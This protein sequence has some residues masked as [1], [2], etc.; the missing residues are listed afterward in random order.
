MLADTVPKKR[1]LFPQFTR[2]VWISPRRRQIQ[3]HAPAKGCKPAKSKFQLMCTTQCEVW[4]VDSPLEG[5]LGNDMYSSSR[6]SK[7]GFWCG[8][9]VVLWDYFSW[10]STADDCVGLSV[11]LGNNWHKQLIKNSGTFATHQWECIV[12]LLSYHSS[13]SRKRQH[14]ASCIIIYCNIGEDEVGRLVR[15]NFLGAKAGGLWT[16]NG[17]EGKQGDLFFGGSFCSTANFYL[18]ERELV[19]STKETKMIH[20]FGPNKNIL[21]N[22]L[23]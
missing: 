9:R 19:D 1:L 2:A 14:W 22:I 5:S 13:D 23:Y 20:C 7:I 18:L 3:Q 11:S 15:K 17:R 10:T 21:H 16:E 6:G 12:H 4:L 8:R